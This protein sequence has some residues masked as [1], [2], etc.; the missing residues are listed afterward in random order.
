LVDGPTKDDAGGEGP[1]PNCGSIAHGR[2]CS[3]CGQARGALLPSVATWIEEAIDEFLGVDGRLPRSIKALAW[4]PGEL[5]LEWRRGRRAHYVSP[6]R[7]YVVAAVLFFLVWPSTGFAEG[8]EEF[9]RGFVDASGATS[10]TA[11]EVS[12]EFGSQVVTESLPGLL[13]IFLV[14]VFAALLWALNRGAGAFV[15]HL[16]MALHVHAVFF[17]GIVATAPIYLMLGERWASLGEPVLFLALFSFL[18]A[19]IARVYAL[20]PWRSVGRALAVISAYSAVAA[21]AVA[22]LLFVVL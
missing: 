20:S 1:C 9:I 10:A 13:I 7:L 8:L 22:G 12:V 5:T 6:L 14:P 17:A 16:V 11:S 19:S 3:E 15:G 18:C 2:F 21:V 4:P